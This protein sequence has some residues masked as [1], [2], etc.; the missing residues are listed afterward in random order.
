[1]TWQE[2]MQRVLWGALGKEYTIFIQSKY[3]FLI[4]DGTTT[5]LDVESIYDLESHWKGEIRKAILM[6][7]ENRITDIMKT[8]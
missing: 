3:R 6:V 4:I 5:I 7:I 8:Y 1:M 2:K